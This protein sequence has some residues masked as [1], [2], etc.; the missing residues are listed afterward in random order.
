DVVLN[1]LWRYTSLQNTFS[2]MNIALVNRQPRTLGLREMIQL[3]IEH[4][5]DVITRR[6]QFLLRKAQQE[7]HLKEGLIYAACDIDEVIKLIRS[8]RTRDEAIDRLMERGFRIPDGHEF[9]PRIPQRMLEQAAQSSEGAVRLSKAQ[10]EAIGRMQLISLV[11]LEVDKLVGEYTKLVE[12]I[13]EYESI[14]GDEKRVLEII[15]TDTTEIKEKFATPRL[16]RLE[17][18]ELEDVADGDL[19]PVDDVVVTISHLG[20]V[21]RLPVDGYRTQGRGGRGVIGADI[22]QDD[23]TEHLFVCSTHDDILCFTNTG[24]V[25]KIKCFEI[26]QSSRTARGRA[27][28]NLL[29][30]KDGETV[31][32]FLPIGDF[33]KHENFL[34]FTTEQGL[35]KRTSL[36]LYR[37]VKRSGL[38]AINL[39]EGDR[40]V[41]VRV[42]TGEDHILL[43]TRSGMSIRFDENDARAMGRTAAGVKGIS[44][45]GDDRVVAMV[46]ADDERQLLTVCANGYGKRTGT[47]EY[48]V[49]SEDGSTRAQSRGGKGRVDIRASDRNGPVVAALSVTPEDQMMLITKK[50]M[51]VR[52]NVGE[53]RQTGRATQGVRVIN[54]KEAD[55]LVAVARIDESL[56]AVVAQREGQTDSDGG[57]DDDIGS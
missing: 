46:V 24:R 12:Q 54:L 44:L 4:R 7:A 20:Y 5:K 15:R 36:K 37:N 40:L 22:K 8:S 28:V 53:V 21:K 11:A 16:T 50:G 30:L 38:I 10:A 19:I 52:S 35:V 32:A 26:P 3:F 9:A 25:F 56:D 47:I 55:C 51:I 1:Q 34:V 14:L 23:F 48:L 57:Q 6:T 2:I 39:K 31:R 45:R 18:G 27:I 41:D 49:H 29:S 33:E 17:E 42:T 13:E 43:C